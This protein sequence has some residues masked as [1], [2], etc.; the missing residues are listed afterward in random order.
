MGAQDGKFAEINWDLNVY[1]IEMLCTGQNKIDYSK[2]INLIVEVHV[3]SDY[4]KKPTSFLKRT[5][6]SKILK[7]VILEMLM[8]IYFDSVILYI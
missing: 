1:N 8:C 2:Y 5:M 7:K 4:K 3:H 6:G